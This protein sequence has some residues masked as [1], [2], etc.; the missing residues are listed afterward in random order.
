MARSK[1]LPTI[2]E[3]T[4]GLWERV[5]WLLREY[6]PPKTTGRSRTNARG[7]LNGIIF[8]FRTGCQW[9]HIP[10]VYG[11]D[12]TIH[13]TFQRWVEIN[14][15][16]M[17]W[18]LLAAECNELALVDWEWQTA[19]GWLGKARSGGR[20]NRPQS[21]RPRKERDQE[22][23]LDGRCWRSVINCHRSGQC[24]RS[25]TSGSDDRGDGH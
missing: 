1:S 18:S 10:K 13:R 11:D 7:I 12:S 8:R 6:D 15:F 3:V 9:N 16:E 4:D 25:Q 5:E 14:L 24:Q 20:R 2:W 22:E 17:I 21:D 19:D 23:R